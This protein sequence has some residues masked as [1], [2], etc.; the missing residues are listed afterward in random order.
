VVSSASA[1]APWADSID[2][3]ARASSG[4][5]NVGCW[6]QGL[7]AGRKTTVEEESS[8]ATGGVCLCDSSGVICSSS[9]SVSSSSGTE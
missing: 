3:C 1:G 8:A 5:S 9:G 2:A 7:A 6:V 4:S